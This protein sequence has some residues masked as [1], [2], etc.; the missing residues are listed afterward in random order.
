MITRHGKITRFFSFFSCA[1]KRVSVCRFKPVIIR[2]RFRF[3][4]RI[5]ESGFY[6]QRFCHSVCLNFIKKLFVI[7]RFIPDVINIPYM[8]RD[9]PS[10]TPFN[11]GVI[12]SQLDNVRV[13]SQTMEDAMIF[14]FSIVIQYSIGSHKKI[15]FPSQKG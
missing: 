5:I 13:F 14:F 11:S 3:M 6:F 15:P 10:P 8:S 7:K 4:C 9:I 1:F 2:L 12:F